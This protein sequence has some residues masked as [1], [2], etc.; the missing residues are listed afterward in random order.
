MPFVARALVAALAAAVVAAVV[1]PAAPGA[2]RI[3]KIYYDSPGADTGSNASRNAEWIRL[4]NTGRTT[5]GLSGWSIGD[6]L[7]NAYYFRQFSLR[8][9][10]TV[11]IHTGSGSETAR[12]RYWHSAGY[13]WG[14]NR[15]TARLRRPNGRLADRCSYR[16]SGSASSVT[17]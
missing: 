7:G 11:T 6:A 12:H 17:C 3:T 4:K 5:R 9:G 13:I 10:R 14:N 16:D 15:D 1:A 2:I 8:P